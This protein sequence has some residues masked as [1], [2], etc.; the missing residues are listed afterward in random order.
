MFFPY[1][2]DV[3]KTLKIMAALSEKENKQSGSCKNRLGIY[4]NRRRGSHA[5][6]GDRMPSAAIQEARCSSI[7][8]PATIAIGRIGKL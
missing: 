2:F 1:I 6:E 5:Y 8:R 3:L 7:G 4:S